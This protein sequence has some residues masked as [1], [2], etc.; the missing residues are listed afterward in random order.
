M[1]CVFAFIYKNWHFP[2]AMFLLAVPHFE[3]LF[4]ASM[5]PLLSLEF[6]SWLLFFEGFLPLIW[7]RTSKNSRCNIIALRME[8]S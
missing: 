1:F 6:G 3:C 4:Q 7:H 2:V 8:K 5:Q